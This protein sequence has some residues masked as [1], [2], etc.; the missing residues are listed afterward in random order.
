ETGELLS[1]DAYT[2]DNGKSFTVKGERTA[3]G[4]SVAAT[5]EVN[6]EMS[7]LSYVTDREIVSSTYWDPRL[8]EQSKVLNTQTGKLSEITVTELPRE[9]VEIGD[10]RF[11]ATPYR[12]EGGLNIDIYYDDELCLAKLAFKAPKDQSV[13]SGKLETHFQKDFVDVSMNDHP[14]LG[15]CFQEE[16]PGMVSASARK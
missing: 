1:I 5:R 4:F 13:I 10:S 3:E 16:T 12:L 14:V 6:G 7:D 8:R 9:W 15:R 11:P 2:Y